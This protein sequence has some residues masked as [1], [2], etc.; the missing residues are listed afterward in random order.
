METIVIKTDA[1]R[2][3]EEEFFLFCQQNK[4][5]RIERTANK[6][7][8]IMSPAGFN[9]GAINSILNNKL[10]QWNGL[11]QSGVTLDSSVGFILPNGAMRSPDVSWIL[12]ERLIKFTPEEK[13]RFLKTCPDFVIELKSPSDQL[14][15]LQD[16][17]GEWVSNGCRLAWL[18]NPEDETVA[19]YRKDGSKGMVSGFDNEL[20][21]EDVLPG[22]KLQLSA[23]DF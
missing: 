22:F 19:I 12:K 5:L 18:I 7:I 9:S 21:G 10:S 16:K 23:L 17:M 1:L 6:E 20:D 14:K 4:E 13:K 8:I 2:M 3:T 11:L 15:Q